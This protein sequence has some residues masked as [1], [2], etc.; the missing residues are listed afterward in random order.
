[1]QGIAQWWDA[2]LGIF[3][4]TW[5]VLGHSKYKSQSMNSCVEEWSHL[6]SLELKSV[7]IF[8]LPLDWLVKQLSSLL[9]GIPTSRSYPWVRWWS[10]HIGDGG[11]FWSWAIGLCITW[12]PVCTT[13]PDQ[14]P[15][16]FQGR[17]RHRNPW[18]GTAYTTGCRS[19]VEGYIWPADV[20]CLAYTRF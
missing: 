20:L 16:L 14:Q 9:T 1:M 18:D 3:C 5:Q 6:F 12:A 4:K 10:Q 8:N 19:M 7:S 2:H 15:L 11:V 17:R 13:P